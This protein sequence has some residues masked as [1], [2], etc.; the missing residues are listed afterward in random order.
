MTKVAKEGGDR[1]KLRQSRDLDIAR[2]PMV[3]DDDTQIV[4]ALSRGLMILEA[5]RRTDTS[6]G[7]AELAERTGLTKPTV[8]RLTYTLARH[9][10]LS[11][12]QHQ[13]EYRLGVGAVL[14]GAVAQAMT[15]VR[16][17]ALPLMRELVAGG[18]FNVGLGTRAGNQ[19][20]YTDACES[21]ALISLRL[22]AGSRIPIA[23]SAMGRA[24]LASLDADERGALLEELRGRYDD[25]WAGIV[26]GVDAATE[27]L[28][29]YGYCSSLGDWQKDIHGVA[30]P[31]AA[32][33]GELVYVLNLGGAAYALPE[34]EIRERHAP[35]LVALARKVEA[36][37][38]LDGSFPI[39]S[40]SLQPEAVE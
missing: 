40:R 27:E 19:M 21:E 38:G 24:Y 4:G 36:A 15:N 12:N 5:F 34:Q 3:E 7:N 25:D 33:A 28:E 9:N 16:T 32:P 37:L 6:L 1:S 10:Y 14:L 23:T 22:N 30:V 2:A 26:A 17:V 29:R 8:S 31:I 11:F 18:R 13:R 39:P 20:V 35:R